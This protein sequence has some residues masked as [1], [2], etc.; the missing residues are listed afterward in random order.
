MTKLT[1]RQAPDLVSFHRRPLGAYVAGDGFAF[2]CP[3]RR[4]TG[5]AMWGDP[6]ADAMRLACRA[7]TVDEVRETEHPWVGY[8][9]AR[10]LTAASDEAF[11]I[12]F[13]HTRAQIARI[14]ARFARQAIV[15]PAGLLG[16]VSTGFWTMLSPPYPFATFDEPDAA[17]EWLGLRATPEQRAV[18][19]V[20]AGLVATPPWLALLRSV[21]DAAR[22]P[23]LE[24]VATTLR[25]S[26]RSLQ[27][28]LASAGTSFRAEVAGAR[29]RRA[30]RLIAAR[31]EPT[32]APPAS[33]P[34]R[35]RGM[36]AE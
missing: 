7:M 19:E 13:E 8:A 9:D 27:R 18:D 17:W 23:S 31:D 34:G 33:S 35:A 15:R 29:A 12:L 11:R 16:S 6:T 25:F 28:H 20:I 22:R 30:V 14:G 36:A 10:G 2:L 4:L 21:L 32:A 5:F 24:Q 3:T 1:L 26:E